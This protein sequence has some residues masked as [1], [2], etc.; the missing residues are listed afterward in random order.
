MASKKAKKVVAAIAPKKPKIVKTTI[1][2][3]VDVVVL[4]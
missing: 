3:M 1:Q 2:K 4:S